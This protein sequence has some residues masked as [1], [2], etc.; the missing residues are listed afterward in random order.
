[1][2]GEQACSGGA[3]EGERDEAVVEGDPFVADQ[4]ADGREQGHLGLRLVV[5]LDYEDVRPRSRR[6]HV[7]VRPLA[8]CG[9]QGCDGSPD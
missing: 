4:A 5:G 9:Q 8:R 2:A 7:R 1:M 3:A 6:R